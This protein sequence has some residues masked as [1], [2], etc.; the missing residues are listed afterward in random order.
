LERINKQREALSQW[1]RTRRDKNF[2]GGDASP[3]TSFLR[4]RPSNTFPRFQRSSLEGSDED[5][6]E[7]KGDTQTQFPLS[8]AVMDSPDLL[9]S[10]HMSAFDQLVSSHR[11][12]R[13]VDDDD[14]EGEDDGTVDADEWLRAR[15]AKRRLD[16]ASA[17]SPVD[18][19]PNEPHRSRKRMRVP[20]SQSSDGEGVPRIRV[21]ESQLEMASD[22]TR[23]FVPDSQVKLG[24]EDELESKPPVPVEM[25]DAPTTHAVSSARAQADQALRVTERVKKSTKRV[26]QDFEG[27]IKAFQAQQLHDQ[28]PSS[29]AAAALVPSCDPSTSGVTTSPPRIRN[30]ILN[31]V[32]MRT[33]AATPPRAVIKEPTLLTRPPLPASS[34][35]S[36]PM[37]SK[38][39]EGERSFVLVGT[40]LSKEEAKLIMEACARLGG[41]FGRHF[42]SKRNRKTGAEL[43]S[44]THLITKAVPPPFT[45]ADGE[46]LDL[47]GLRCKRTAKY[48]QALAEGAFVVDVKWVT[49]SLSAGKWLPED[50]FEMEGDMYSDAMGKPRESRLRRAQTGRRNDIFSM[51]RFVMLCQDEEFEYQL[52]SV[53]SVVET[54]G[55]VVS[56]SH[57][58]D[59]LSSDQRARKTPIGIVS[60]S[61]PSWVAKTRW[62]QY[63]IP[64]VRVTWLFD[65]ISHV[66]VLPF[67][68]YYPY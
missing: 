19:Q 17:S 60:K 5:E 63:Q 66:E 40:D 53:R 15:L 25:Q 23:I 59:A 24:E 67:D 22:D 55:G 16:L 12:S 52:Q 11:K 9:S 49:D 68:D 13:R 32:M 34:N 44:V 28:K 26:S 3:M 35:D 62:Q 46:V 51:F 48:M 21:E 38:N 31:A 41:R 20:S 4:S 50:P 43:S 54:F 42:D 14:D 18:T 10:T 7:G 2:D 57:E 47:P 30:G 8:A 58:F 29:A 33:V 27:A 56:W 6:R 36:T 61:L 1:E 37:T 64:I 45:S 65:S 39:P